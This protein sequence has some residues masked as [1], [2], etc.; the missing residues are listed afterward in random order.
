MGGKDNANDYPQ[1]SLR[2]HTYTSGVNLPT[3]SSPVQGLTRIGSTPMNDGTPQAANASHERLN[4]MEPMPLTWKMSGHN[5][6]TIPTP[7]EDYICPESTFFC[8][9]KVA[10]G[11]AVENAPLDPLSDKG[12]MSKYRKT[13][14]NLVKQKSHIL[15][16]TFAVLASDLW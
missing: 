14:N 6:E 12:A 9:Q 1:S 10:F 8:W 11:T 15:K 4:W 13:R 5:L 2:G 16:E 3:Y 7:V